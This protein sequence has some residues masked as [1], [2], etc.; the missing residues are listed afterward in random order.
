MPSLCIEEIEGNL[1]SIF[2]STQNL[3]EA[4]LQFAFSE[5]LYPTPQFA[6]VGLNEVP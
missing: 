4:V 3:N 6:T 2:F 5:I 1:L